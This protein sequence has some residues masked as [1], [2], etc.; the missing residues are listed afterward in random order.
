MN[1]LKL[2][3]VAVK[4]EGGELARLWCAWP[5]SRSAESM[6]WVS[7]DVLRMGGLTN[8]AARAYLIECLEW[9]RGSVRSTRLG[10][11]AAGPMP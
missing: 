11:L 8:P 2:L 10:Q 5:Y 7:D 4:A 9:S 3:A 1:N 6:E